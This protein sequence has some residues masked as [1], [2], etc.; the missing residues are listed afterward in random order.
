MVSK[1]VSFGNRWSVLL[2]KLDGE[3]QQPV[4]ELFLCSL[5]LRVW[6]AVDHLDLIGTRVNLIRIWWLHLFLAIVI[7][8]NNLIL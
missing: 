1:N 8:G 2:V 4:I 3:L 7:V 5:V 6:L